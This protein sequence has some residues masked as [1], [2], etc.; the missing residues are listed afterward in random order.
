MFRNAFAF[1]I[2]ASALAF[3]GCSKCSEQPVAAPPAAVDTP[4]AAEGDSATP[5]VDGAAAPADAAPVAEP[6]PEAK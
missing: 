1:V 3:T 5:A 6:T 2:V 4:A